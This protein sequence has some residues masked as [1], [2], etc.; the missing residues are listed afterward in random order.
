MKIEQSRD[1]KKRL[2]SALKTLEECSQAKPALRGRHL[3]PQRLAQ[4]L[5]FTK[6]WIGRIVK[7]DRID[8]K[9]LQALD[10]L[11][12]F[13]SILLKA[14][15]EESQNLAKRAQELLQ[16]HHS[17][18]PSFPFFSARVDHFSSST[19]KVVD[20]VEAHTLSPY[21]CDAF[22]MKALA[23]AREYL[24]LFSSMKA[25]IEA[26]H[27]TKVLIGEYSSEILSFKQTLRPLPGET[28]T[29]TGRFQRSLQPGMYE[30]PMKDSFK[31]M[32]TSSLTGFPAPLTHNGW[33]LSSTFLPKPSL[34]EAT[35]GVLE[36][37]QDLIERL[38]GDHSLFGRLH[39]HIAKSRA[40]SL[41]HSQ[42]FYEGHHRRA[43]ALGVFAK[44]R[45]CQPLT[46]PY[47]AFAALYQEVHTSVVISLE[48]GLESAWLDQTLPALHSS[49]VNVR[50]KGVWKYLEAI[51]Q[52]GLSQ[53]SGPHQMYQR[54]VGEI[55][56]RS[57]MRLLLQPFS[58]VIEI[59]A[60]Q[61]T[62]MDRRLQQVAIL[63]FDVFEQMLDGSEVDF[64]SALEKE[65]A[66]LE[67][68]NR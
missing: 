6:E 35:K 18:F 2:Q 48:K 36:R 52:N 46:L 25:L 7:A 68:R 66:I 50:Q 24:F 65:I 33:A 64:C 8:E 26:V 12:R 51:L 16:A 17:T 47:D 58:E 62:V 5:Q 45:K 21:A 60:P 37:H 34:R 59:P 15:C 9:T 55:L 39:A 23:L 31:G 41:A 10:D 61:L 27:Q 63:Q 4:A 14:P 40:W 54:I 29:I 49:H 32:R 20:Y 42:Q 67:G 30:V 56:G 28:L 38:R 1:P 13:H 11:K 53:L 3:K 19:D 43:Q 57:A 22:R 44:G